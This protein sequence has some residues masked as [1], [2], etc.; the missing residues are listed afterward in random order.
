VYTRTVTYQE[1]Q[2]VTFPSPHTW[3]KICGVFAH[4]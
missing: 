1:R 4:I 3:V 2:E